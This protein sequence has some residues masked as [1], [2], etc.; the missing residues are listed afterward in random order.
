V[1]RPL[2]LLRMIRNE[3]PRLGVK[4]GA[5]LSEDPVRLMVPVT[6]K[7]MVSSP[8]GACVLP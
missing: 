4:L 7:V 5:K 6:P 2:L 8:D 3:S 1:I